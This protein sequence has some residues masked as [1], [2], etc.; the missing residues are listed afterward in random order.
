MRKN[1]ELAHF[2]HTK[3]IWHE[4]RHFYFGHALPCPLTTSECLEFPRPL[5]MDPV[6]S[7]YKNIADFK[8]L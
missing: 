8:L 1:R 5:T 2:Q 6:F 7:L 4:E 3:V